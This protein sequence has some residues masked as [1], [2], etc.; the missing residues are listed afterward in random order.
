M[1][2]PYFLPLFSG[3]VISYPAEVDSGE[4]ATAL[5]EKRSNTATGTAFLLTYDITNSTNNVYAKVSYS[6]LK[7]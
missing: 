1:K 2:I 7:Y 3:I 6:R 4:E 5:Y